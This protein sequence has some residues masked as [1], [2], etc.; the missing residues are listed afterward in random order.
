MPPEATEAA[1]VAAPEAAERAALIAELDAADDAETESTSGDRGARKDD[2]DAAS[3]DASV[4]EDEPAADVEES[5]EEDEAAEGS[6]QTAAEMA[7]H[8][9][10]LLDAGDMR[11][12]EEALG[13]EKGAL[14]IN[15]AKFRYVRQQV[16]K[17][18]E[19]TQRAEARAAQADTVIQS[20]QQVYGPMVQAKQLFH[21]GT[22]QG[23]QQAARFVETHF[24]VPLT[25]FVEA[26][27]K[28]GRGESSPQRGPDP[29]VAELKQ[30]VQQLLQERNNQQTMAQ[31]QAAEQRHLTTIKGKLGGTPLA[32]LPDGAKVVYETI[33]RSYDASIQG[34]RLNLKD[35]IAEAQKDPA[36][37]WRLHEL[38]QKRGAKPADK[39]AP[40]L[41]R[42][43]VI[44]ESKGLSPAQK[45]SAEKAR[46]IAELE[47]EERKQERVSR[48][49]NGKR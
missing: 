20:A 39:P 49:S 13:L 18:T 25:T 42:K 17:A 30:T 26:V 34:Y 32:K 41:A 38:S 5:D 36:V 47:A 33:K 37:K 23:V 14:K 9:K 7:E 8:I 35:A 11:K 31:Q 19:A 4:S 21:D 15:G 48:R 16:Q 24:G 44:I 43:R 45:E 10:G 40:T 6:P 29:E 28:A 22:A 1:P 27:V 3:D 46:L 2:E 12:V